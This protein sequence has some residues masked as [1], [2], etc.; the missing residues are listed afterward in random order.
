MH[1][2]NSWES[3][4]LQKEQKQN[5]TRPPCQKRKNGGGTWR[6]DLKTCGML[7]LMVLM[8]VMC[9]RSNPD[10]GSENLHIAKDTSRVIEKMS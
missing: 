2:G 7:N 9:V 6:C 10:T 8:Q 3:D 4:L 5:P 1:Q